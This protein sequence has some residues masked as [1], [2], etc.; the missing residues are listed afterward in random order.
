[1]KTRV[2]LVEDH[3]GIVQNLQDYLDEDSYDLHVAT[4]GEDGLE[5]A[6][7]SAFDVLVLDLTLPGIDGLEVCRRL[8]RDRG[9]DLPVLMLTARD[10]LPDKLEGFRVGTDDYLTK[11]FAPA[12]LEARIQVLAKRRP[13]RKVED[14]VVGELALNVGTREVTRRGNLLSISPTGFRILLALMK[15]HPNVVTRDELEELI[16]GG[17][18]PGSDSLRTHMASLR[19]AVDKPFSFAVIETLYGVGFRLRSHASPHA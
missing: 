18:P 2:L 4:T 14:L 17:Q 16:W 19:K 10:T 7:A 8:R 1:M 3:P 9:S 15:A 13:L 12:E 5:Q 11:P 6:A